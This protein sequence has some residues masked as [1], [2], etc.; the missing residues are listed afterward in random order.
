MLPTPTLPPGLELFR[1]LI[2][3]RGDQRQVNFAG[4]ISD[5]L[6]RRGAL[7]RYS[8]NTPLYPAWAK[9]CNKR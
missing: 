1:P 9:L 5:V 4:Q 2:G 3:G 7:E 6:E 8:D